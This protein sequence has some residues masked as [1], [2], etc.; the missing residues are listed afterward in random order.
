MAMYFQ[1]ARSCDARFQTALTEDSAEGVVLWHASAAKE[2]NAAE[3]F[4]CAYGEYVRLLP[5]WLA[6]DFTQLPS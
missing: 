2:R 1:H 6:T 4:S 3:N 5:A